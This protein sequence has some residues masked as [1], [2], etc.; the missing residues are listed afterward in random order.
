MNFSPKKW[1]KLLLPLVFLADLKVIQSPK[2]FN[3]LLHS[4]CPKTIAEVQLETT[5]KMVDEEAPGHERSALQLFDEYSLRD[6][7]KRYIPALSLDRGSRK[8]K[9]QFGTFD[10]MYLPKFSLVPET[11]KDL[12]RDRFFL[13]ID[14]S[15]TPSN[16][17]SDEMLLVMKHGKSRDEFNA[18]N[19]L[20][21]FS[22]NPCVN[23]STVFVHGTAL[24]PCVWDPGIFLNSMVPTS[25]QIQ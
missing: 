12:N 1:R 5:I 4:C 22:Y 19:I 21:Q 15:I 17:P 3:D 11:F 24:N 23:S 8:R 7:S 20:S 2:V 14:A 13:K 10:D 18:Y 25:I 6:M 9:I 16:M